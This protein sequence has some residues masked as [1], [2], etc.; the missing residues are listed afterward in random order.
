[1]H[2]HKTEFIILNSD[3]YFTIARKVNGPSASF[4]NYE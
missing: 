1:M 2:Y 4:F 3:A